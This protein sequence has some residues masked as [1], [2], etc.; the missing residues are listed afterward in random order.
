[1]AGGRVVFTAPASGAS[2]VLPG[3]G[4]ATIGPNHVAQI[5]PLA[6]N[7]AGTYT[8]TARVDRGNGASYTLTNVAPIGSA[9]PTAAAQTATIPQ[10]TRFPNA[11]SS[12]WSALL[13]ARAEAGS[14]AASHLLSSRFS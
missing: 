13:A 1:M 9:S 5:R 2:A 4:V 3:G 7:V 12:R 6:N 14:A 10:P 8:V 11:A